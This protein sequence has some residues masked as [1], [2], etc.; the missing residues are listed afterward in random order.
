MKYGIRHLIKKIE[1]R[2]T[3]Y[4]RKVD[5]F[6]RKR[7]NYIIPVSSWLIKD[8]ENDELFSFL[9]IGWDQKLCYYWLNRFPGEFEIRPEIKNIASWNI[10]EFLEKNN[11][12]FDL[13]IIESTKKAHP[14][15]YP[16]SFLLP[17]WMEMKLDTESFLKKSHC[18]KLKKRIKKYSLGYEIRTGIE[19]F[20]LFY[21]TMHKPYILKRHGLSADLP[22]YK[23]FHS[24]WFNT[25]WVLFFLTR[26]N[27]PVAAKFIGL[28]QGRYRLIF[29]GIKDGSDEIVKMGTIGALS[30]FS[31]LYYYE[32]GIKS[33]LAGVSM[34]VVFDGVTQSKLLLGA[35][36]Y[37]KDLEKRSKYYFI[38]VSTKPLTIK[39]LKSNPLFYLSGGTLNIALFLSAEDYQSKEEFFKFFNRLKTIK[40]NMTRIICFDNPEKIIQ[41]MNE[42]NITGIEVIKYTQKSEFP[43]E[44]FTNIYSIPH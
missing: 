17:R 22:D 31:M 23:H 41:W 2:I 40:V 37:L 21:H 20:D 9:F 42:E 15:K 33:M 4:Y 38:P 24:K 44:K 7:G 3:G 10:P 32:K 35:Q 36:P 34:P 27:E 29:M 30:Y 39:I 25:Q 1:G 13:V 19:A 18:K 6:I 11:G 26:E 14:G 5:L 16:G 12:K 43:S 8:H 28:K